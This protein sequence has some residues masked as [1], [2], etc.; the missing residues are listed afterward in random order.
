MRGI[1]FLLFLACSHAKSGNSPKRSD[2]RFS[3]P[4]Q[5]HEQQ[6]VNWSDFG[7]LMPIDKDSEWQEYRQ[8]VGN[9]HELFNKNEQKPKK[10]RGRPRNPPV[11]VD[12]TFKSNARTEVGL[13]R[14]KAKWLL[15][16][17]EPEKFKRIQQNHYDRKREREARILNG[18]NEEVQAYRQKKRE[19][20]AKKMQRHKERTGF[21]T[22][23]SSK[24]HKLKTLIESEKGTPE[25]I[26]ELSKMREKDRTRHS[27][28]RQRKKVERYKAIY[29]KHA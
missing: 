16:K 29:N 3:T 10:K 20:T 18:T 8:K 15:Q 2:Q 22:Y 24:I 9:D 23:R 7:D 21:S 5:N 14:A 1:L 26:D 17:T 4:T 12:E 25:D 13:Q 28:H 19:N 11:I 27:L 6:G